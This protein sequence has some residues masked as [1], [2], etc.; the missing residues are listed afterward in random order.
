MDRATFESADPILDEIGAK[1]N[2]IL[3]SDQFAAFRT[4]LARLGEAVG[5]RYSVD[6]TVGVEVFDLE[7]SHALPLLTI[8]VSSCKGET[9]HKTRRDATRQKYVVE[10]EIQVVPHNHCPL[11]YGVWDF[12]FKNHSCSECGATLGKEVKLLLDHDLCPFCEE[13]KVSLTAP[14]C[15]KC[16]QRVDPRVVVWG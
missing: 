5:S 14:V 10:G 8:G 11:C 4:L 9:P 3:D 6:L 12:K 15:N 1:L 16:G 2:E 7:R 13:G